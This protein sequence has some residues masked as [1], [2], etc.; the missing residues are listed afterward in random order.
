MLGQFIE[1]S[2]ES[3]LTFFIRSYRDPD[4]IISRPRLSRDSIE[5]ILPGLISSGVAA[6]HGRTPLVQYGA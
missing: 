3:K 2:L 6:D 4:P 1:G 5:S